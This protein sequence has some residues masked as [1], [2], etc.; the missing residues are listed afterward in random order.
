MKRKEWTMGL[1]FVYLAFVVWVILLKFNITPADLPHLRNI[2]L[3]LYGDSGIINGQLD[4]RELVENILIFVPF[5]VYA[6]MLVKERSWWKVI[7][8]GAGF[9]LILE[10]LQYV[11][12]IG[13]SDITDVINN[14]LGAALGMLFVERISSD[15]RREK[16]Y[17]CTGHRDDRNSRHD[18]NECPAPDRKYIAVHR[19]IWKKSD[20][21]YTH[22]GF[23]FKYL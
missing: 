21:M 2:N 22:V 10:T 5:G 19:Y 12:A 18:R 16:L 15:R 14:T 3:I 17:D 9:S 7:L 13:A 4:V 20:K 1:Y 8:A 23:L 6:G 11:F